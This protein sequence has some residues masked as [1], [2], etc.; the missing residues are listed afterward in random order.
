MLEYKKVLENALLEKTELVICP[1]FPYLPIMHSD[2]FL[3][4]AQDVSEYERGSFT[5]EVSAECLK[6]LD[7]KYVII[8]H[9]EREL[10]FLENI[11][12]KKRKIKN[13]LENG[14][15]VILPIGESLMEYQL[16]KTK[17]VILNKLNELLR[18]L[19][20]HNKQ[21]IIV[22]YEPIWMIGKKETIKK[23]EVIDN[24]NFIKNWLQEYGFSNIVVYGGS[25]TEENIQNMPEIDG[26]LLGKM[27]LNV[28]KLVK[29]I[30][31]N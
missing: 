4:G 18:D 21:N 23:Q 1:Q 5:G 17:E 8:G 11:E 28:E 2:K 19:P 13:A 31:K 24:I 6:S 9:Y 16:G 22:A 7:V 27:S 12:M 25:L 30:V 20:E 15:K 14:L 3:L 29:L 26:F 10:Y